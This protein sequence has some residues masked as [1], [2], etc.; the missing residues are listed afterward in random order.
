MDIK[1]VIFNESKSLISVLSVTSTWIKVLDK[2]RG[3][4]STWI[5]VSDKHKNY[6]N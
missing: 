6:M 2:N 4:T 1:N 3:L 5:N